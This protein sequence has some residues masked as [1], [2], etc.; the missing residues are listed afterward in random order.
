MLSPL[1]EFMILPGVN[2]TRSRFHK[3]AVLELKGIR[4]TSDRPDRTW[5]QFRGYGK[6][7]NSILKAGTWDMAAIWIVVCL[8]RISQI[9]YLSINSYSI[10]I[11]HPKASGKMRFV[12]LRIAMYTPMLMGEVTKYA[13]NDRLLWMVLMAVLSITVRVSCLL[14]QVMLSCHM[15]KYATTPFSHEHSSKS[16]TPT[17]SFVFTCCWSRKPA[18]A[19]ISSTW[20][21]AF[22]SSPS[23]SSP[24]PQ[25]I[26]KVS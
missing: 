9:H 7:H 6:K 12:Q 3:N 19:E 4:D 15:L 18:P 14:S 13:W 11:A 22:S 5:V 26:Q 1:Q 25:H 21:T 20:T 24:S 16:L 23:S 17:V 10:A 8:C 2:W